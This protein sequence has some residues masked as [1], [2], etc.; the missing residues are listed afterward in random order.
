MPARGGQACEARG[1]G[2][3]VSRGHQSVGET[4]EPAGRA[5]SGGGV[6]AVAPEEFVAS[7]AGEGDLDVSAGGSGDPIGREERA[8]AERL[9]E[10][11]D[12]FDQVFGGARVAV[13]R[14]VVGP[15]RVRRLF[16]GF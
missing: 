9:A 2:V 13:E 12:Q 7:V 10:R 11:L 3:G 6:S 15:D 14:L 8:V 5:G 16:G 1:E 4:G